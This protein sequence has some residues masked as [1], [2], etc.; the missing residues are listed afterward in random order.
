MK[1]QVV[2]P[3]RNPGAVRLLLAATA[4]VVFQALAVLVLGPLARGPSVMDRPTLPSLPAW[5]LWPSRILQ[6]IQSWPQSVLLLAV[7]IGW[8]I[9]LRKDPKTWILAF[10]AGALAVA[11]LFQ[12]LSRI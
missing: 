4:G 6:W 9:A 3:S 1:G 2:P 8:V 10:L 7:L 5:L 12:I 11:V